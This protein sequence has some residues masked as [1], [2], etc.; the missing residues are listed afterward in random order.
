[1]ST[2]AVGLSPKMVV[3]SLTEARGSAAAPSSR[4]S[5]LTLPDTLPLA[6]PDGAVADEPVAP[7]DGGVVTVPVEPDALPLA[8]PPDGAG[9]AGA[10]GEPLG[11]L[12][13]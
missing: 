9:V 3:R 8:L 12:P 11:L 4:R 10:D 13:A 2:A 6:P 7:P 5:V 1:M